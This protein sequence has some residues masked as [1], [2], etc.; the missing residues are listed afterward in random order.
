MVVW[1]NSRHGCKH[2]SCHHI[3]K[4]EEQI[5]CKTPCH[6]DDGVERSICQQVEENHE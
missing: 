3:E 2:I 1:C 6:R 5:E 4:H